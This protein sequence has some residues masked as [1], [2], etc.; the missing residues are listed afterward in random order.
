[1]I[2]LEREGLVDEK[3]CITMMDKCV[4]EID[5]K[6]IEMSDMLHGPART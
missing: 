5:E 1:L 3:E 2:N 4:S 6:I